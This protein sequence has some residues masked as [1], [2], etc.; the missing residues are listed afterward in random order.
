MRFIS[1]DDC[2]VNIFHGIKSLTQKTAS[3]WIAQDQKFA[4]YVNEIMG[5]VDIT[6]AET[7]GKLWTFSLVYLSMN[8]AWFVACKLIDDSV[9]W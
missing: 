7:N 9:S 4:L 6:L 1:L 5:Y 3:Y 2:E 8:C